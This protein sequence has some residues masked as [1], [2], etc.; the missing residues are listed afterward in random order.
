[1]TLRVFLNNLLTSEETRTRTFYAGTRASGT[2]SKVEVR[3]SDGASEGSRI[4]GFQVS[5]HF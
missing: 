2:L 3:R 1:V 4:I 5:G